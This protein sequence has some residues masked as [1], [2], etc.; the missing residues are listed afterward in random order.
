MKRYS[1]LVL[2]FT[3]ILSLAACSNTKAGNTE[4]CTVT[5]GMSDSFTEKEIKAAVDAVKTKFKK[6]YGGCT[7]VSVTYDETESEL[8]AERYIR[9]GGGQEKGVKAENVIYLF[10]DFKTGEKIEATGFEPNTEY[11]GWTWTVVRESNEKW[12]VTDWGYC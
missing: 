5:I 7:L 3:L 9:S 6:E 10:S 12:Y 11:D 2:V 8:G 1:A 4:N